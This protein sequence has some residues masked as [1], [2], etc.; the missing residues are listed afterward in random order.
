MYLDQGVTEI[1]YNIDQNRWNPEIPESLRFIVSDDTVCT[2]E[3]KR[4]ETWDEIDEKE[5]DKM[6]EMDEMYDDNKFGDTCL[7]HTPPCVKGY[8]AVSQFVKLY[9]STAHL[10]SY[11]DCQR[12]TNALENTCLPLMEDN[13]LMK[14]FDGLWELLTMAHH[15]QWRLI[16]RLLPI[17]CKD[18]GARDRPAF[19]ALFEQASSGAFAPKLLLAL[20]ESAI[21]QSS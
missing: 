12:L 6:D 10:S 11:F 1:V 19:K 8:D 2:D 13:V 9:R 7:T 5:T 17:L 4:G 15:N 21:G 14:L 20:L 3:C 18:K 16:S